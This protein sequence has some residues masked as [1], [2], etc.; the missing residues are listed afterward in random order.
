[1]V[2]LLATA[3]SMSWIVRHLLDTTTLYTV[4][5]DHLTPQEVGTPP[6]SPKYAQ[7][8]EPASEGFRTTGNFHPRALAL[9]GSGPPVVCLAFF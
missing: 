5:C 9:E 1:M 8:T 7:A 4:T 3:R 6:V 2:S